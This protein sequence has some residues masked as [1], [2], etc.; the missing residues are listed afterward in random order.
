M[1]P[2]TQIVFSTKSLMQINFMRDS[3]SA[4]LAVID[5]LHHSVWSN[6]IQAIAFPDQQTCIAKLVDHTGNTIRGIEY[7]LYG[8]FFE[9]GLVQPAPFSFAW[10]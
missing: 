2:D 1:M 7:R 5:C 9:Y 6:D 10:I 8:C 4:E 3:G